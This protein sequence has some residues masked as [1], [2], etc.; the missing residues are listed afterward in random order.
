M[1]KEIKSFI[2]HLDSLEILNKLSDE[3]AG[4]IFKS[5]YQYQKTGEVN[6]L[7]FALDLV[8]SPFLNQFKR[9]KLKW[10]EEVKK[11]SDK[12]KI[13]NLKRWH[14]EIY[15]RFKKGELTLDQ[16]LIIATRSLAIV[17]D[18]LGLPP[19]P[20]SL[21]SKNESKN[22][23][24][25]KNKNEKSE[26]IIP[27]FIDQILFDEFLQQRKKDKNPIEGLALKLTLEDLER[28]ENKNKGNANL[29]VKNAIKGGW[30]SLIEPKTQILGSGY[31]SQNQ[32]S[33][34]EKWKEANGK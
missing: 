15:K 33:D 4:K 28:W 5:I 12:G 19:I 1:I 14:K 23:N 8:L 21:N 6:E 16:A 29:A 13:G 34:Y 18:P 10:D 24:D 32:K 22:E 30:K 2:L 11:S 20:K 26:I 31:N 3:Q 27:N 7:D 9:D 25:N 17:D